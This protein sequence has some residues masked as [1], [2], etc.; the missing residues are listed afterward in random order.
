M[1][2]RNAIGIRPVSGWRRR[3][4]VLPTLLG[5]AVMVAASAAVTA[6]LVLSEAAPEATISTPVVSSFESSPSV[7]DGS[8]L[9]LTVYIVDS[10]EAGDRLQQGLVAAELIGYGSGLPLNPVSVLVVESEDEANLLEARLIEGNSLL[11]VL[12]RPLVR[13]VL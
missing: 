13:V 9:V 6:R 1:S 10:A 5:A 7:V 11:A 4:V 8:E 12:G 3:Q 2:A